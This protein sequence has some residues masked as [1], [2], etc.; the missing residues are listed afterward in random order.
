M[1]NANERYSDK[2]IEELLQMLADERNAIEI[3]KSEISNAI[4]PSATREMRRTLAE[5][6][7]TLRSLVWILKRRGGYEPT[8]AERRGEAIEAKLENIREA[9]YEY[10]GFLGGFTYVTLIFGEGEAVKKQVFSRR[11]GELEE[12]AFASKE[13]LISELKGLYLGE[14]RAS[15]VNHAILDGFQWSLRLTFADGGEEVFEGSNAYPY[16]FYDLKRI[17]GING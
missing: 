14:W 4:Y 11:D 17:F 7:E 13:S 15:Y 8:E 16:N 5:H 3:L 9:R 10:G 12:P 6:R 1:D 2:E